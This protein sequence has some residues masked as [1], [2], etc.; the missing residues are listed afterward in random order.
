[1]K[2][3]TSLFVIIIVSYIII[4]CGRDEGSLG[5]IVDGYVLDATDSTEVP[6]ANVFVL[7]WDGDDRHDSTI[8]FDS[9]CDEK[10]YFYIDFQARKSYNFLFVKAQKEGYNKSSLEHIDEGSTNWAEIYL[11]K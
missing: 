2:I 9:K 1:M 7:Q 5:A 8:V 4:G 3:I 11:Y 6:F 10:G